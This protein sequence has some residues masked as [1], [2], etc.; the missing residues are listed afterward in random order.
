MS[1]IRNSDIDSEHLSPDKTVGT[2]KSPI[3]KSIK[4]FKDLHFVISY[5]KYKRIPMTND[6]DQ[7]TD[8]DASY[9]KLKINLILYLI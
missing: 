1:E 3:R 8:H 2:I 6:S 9:S 7:S 5:A 4:V